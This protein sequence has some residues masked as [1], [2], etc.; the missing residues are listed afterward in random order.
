M[1]RAPKTPRERGSSPISRSISACDLNCV[2]RRRR[3]PGAETPCHELARLAVRHHRSQLEC[4]CA[5]DQ[6]QQLAGDIAGAA[7]NDGWDLSSLTRRPPGAVFARPIALDH[8]I[9]ERGAVAHCVEGGN[10]ELLLDDLH[11]DAG[12]PSQG[13]SPRTA[14]CQ[15]AR[16]AASRRPTPR[17]DRSPTAST[18]VSAARDVGAFENRIDAVGAENAVAQLEHDDVRLAR[19]KLGQ[20][21]ARERR[22]VRLASWRSTPRSVKIIE[23][24]APASS[25]AR[26][27]RR[28]ETPVA[29]NASTTSP[30]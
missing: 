27:S 25:I 30:R 8:A 24:R 17:P 3:W 10:A 4:G 12:C 6:A 29:L 11:A 7:E 23:R 9:A 18:P 5:G 26:I 1:R 28:S 22:T 20:H 21:G 13:R 2:V 15:S 19:R 16:A 14:R